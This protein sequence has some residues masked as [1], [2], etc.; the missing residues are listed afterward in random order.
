[1]KRTS[2]T[3]GFQLPFEYKR[4]KLS[5]TNLSSF[6]CHFIF[7][8]QS[9]PNKSNFPTCI[10]PFVVR[11]PYNRIIIASK[12]MNTSR[13][14]TFRKEKNKKKHQHSCIQRFLIGYSRL[15][16]EGSKGQR[17][18]HERDEKKKKKNK[19]KYQRLKKKKKRRR[20]RSR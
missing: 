1:M 11:N 20:N 4:N 8:R 17:E 16:R 10:F 3:L 15:S 12:I 2:E 14:P 7:Q 6:A 5:R 19:K 18:G 13:I 9:T